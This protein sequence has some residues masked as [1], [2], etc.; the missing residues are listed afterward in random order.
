MRSKGNW[1]LV[2]ALAFFGAGSLVSAVVAYA[3]A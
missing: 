2:V 1:L 3:L